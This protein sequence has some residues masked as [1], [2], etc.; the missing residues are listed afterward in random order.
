MKYLFNIGV[1]MILLTGILSKR[2]L[3]NRRGSLIRYSENIRPLKNRRVI[4]RR[5]KYE[6]VPSYV[7]MD[8]N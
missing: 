5:S 7:N 6:Y 4:G 1:F 8:E 3:R 2:Y